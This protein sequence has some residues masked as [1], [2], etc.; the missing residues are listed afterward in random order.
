M[1]E[2]VRSARSDCAAQ[3]PAVEWTLE[4]IE[5]KGMAGHWNIA[6]GSIVDGKQQFGTVAVGKAAG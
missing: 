1:A 6:E 4:D 5:I 2:S 3:S